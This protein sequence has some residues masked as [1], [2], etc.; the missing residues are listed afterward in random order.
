MSS[1][2]IVIIGGGPA[3][4]VAS[5][6][7]AGLKRKVALI[8]KDKLG[9]ECTI[10]GC[11]PSKALIHSARCVY[12]ASLLKQ[13]GLKVETQELDTSL[14]LEH[15]RDVVQEVYA[16]HTP[17]ILRKSS[18]DV[19]FDE[20]TFKDPYTMQVGNH[21]LRAKKFIIATG[22]R[23]FI[24]P[25][26]GIDKVPYLTNRSLFALSTLP[27]S[28]IILGGGPIGIEMAQSLNRL[29][30]KIT[31]VEMA[32]RI[33]AKEDPE[34]TTLLA[35]QFIAEGVL[36]KTSSKATK[37]IQNNG[38]ITL[39][40]V[41]K[42]NSGTA[43]QAE[44]LLI[45]V[46]RQPNVESLGLENIGVALTSKGIQVNAALQTTVPHIYAC[47][48]IVGPYQFSHMAEYQARI[49][50]RNALFPWFK[51]RVDYTHKTWVTFSDPEL[52]TAGLSEQEARAAYG[53]SI[54][55]YRHS[56]DNTD[57]GKTDGVT[58]G[59]GKF[60]CDRK[61]RILG[62]TIL[63]PRAGELI[64]EIQVGSYYNR[65]LG[66][67]YTIIHPYPT[68]SDV[69]TRAAKDAYIDSIKRNVLLRLLGSLFGYR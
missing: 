1:Y 58:T 49:A 8:E 13:F 6:L 44:T 47:G 34:L 29:G 22:S 2:D 32:D 43:I 27:Q 62:A 61:G 41:D 25:L 56:Y 7:A 60:I 65:R 18:I 10:T 46:G 66:D 12:N 64:G 4:L 19:Y 16:T 63:G 40:L 20:P 21:T 69:I 39:S 55:I 68:Y 45:A 17:E 53:D 31:V 57:R 37:V 14:I 67:L 26:P 59:L 5:K 48:D 54:N 38:F 52:A 30:V 11:I 24:P 23:P 42:E 36:V 9:G 3:G 28:M 15:V 33:L 51:Q 50:V 35:E